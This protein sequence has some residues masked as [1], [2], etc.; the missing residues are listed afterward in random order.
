MNIKPISSRSKIVLLVAAGLIVASSTTAGAAALITGQSVKNESLTGRDIRNGSVKGADI[1]DGSLTK[2]DFTGDLQGPA[3]PQGPKGDQGEQG[4]QG[5]QG[6]QGP[7]GPSGVSG[8][9]YVLVDKVIAGNSQAAWG[10]DCPAGKRALGGGVSSTVPNNAV[11]HESAFQSSDQA[12]G[13]GWWVQ[14][15]NTGASQL[16]AYVWVSCASI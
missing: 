3:G 9:Q 10:A 6:A 15:A 5:P 16:T 8:L 13:T 1:R 4:I 7:Q 14:L 2:D 12:L 11:V